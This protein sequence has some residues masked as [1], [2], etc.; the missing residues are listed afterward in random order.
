M[1][2]IGGRLFSPRFVASSTY[3]LL[4]ASMQA[5]MQVD[6]SLT[7]YVQTPTCPPACLS[8]NQ[9]THLRNDAR[10]L[11]S[12]CISITR[13]NAI[14]ITTAVLAV[15]GTITLIPRLGIQG[16]ISTLGDI[17]F[18]K[19]VAIEEIAGVVFARCGVVVSVVVCGGCLACG[20]A[21]RRV[22]R[23]CVVFDADVA[24]G[25]IDCS[26]EFGGAGE[27]GVAWGR[28]EFG[29]AVGS[30]DDD[31]ELIAVL[32]CVGGGGAGDGTAVQSAFVIGDARGVVTSWAGIDAGVTLDVKIE[33]VAGGAGGVAELLALDRVVLLEGIETQVAA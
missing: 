27:V 17:I 24:A 31:V 22:V 19:N 16:A 11:N 14:I 26:S 21:L 8:V 28:G 5:S 2:V 6:S 15:I 25:C 3:R 12:K 13:A 30:G 10:I 20:C 23:A 29:I 1:I 33:A 32:A 4:Q 18:A 7:R 9:P